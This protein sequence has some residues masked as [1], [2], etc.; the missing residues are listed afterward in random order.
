M[1]TEAGRA[2]HGDDLWT[3]LVA[4]RIQAIRDAGGRTVVTDLRLPHEAE[5]VRS[6][7]GVV[8]KVVRPGQAGLAGAEGTHDTET[9]TDLAITDTTIRNDGTIA[10]LNEQVDRLVL[11]HR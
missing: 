7:G 11:A 1:G 9:L 10:Q 8:I 6:L 2:I 3:N 4:R 5:W